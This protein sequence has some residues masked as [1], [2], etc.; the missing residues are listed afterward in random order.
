MSMTGKTILLTLFFFILSGGS[1]S[2]QEKL[3]TVTSDSTPRTN[4]CTLLQNYLATSTNS[5]EDKKLSQTEK[6]I[7]ASANADEEANVEFSYSTEPTYFVEPTPTPMETE[8][9]TEGVTPKGQAS[10]TPTPISNLQSPAD[11]VSADGPN[12]DSEVMFSLINSHRAELGKPPFQKD[13]ALCSLAKTRSFELHDELFV[14]GNLHSG[15][16]NRNLPYWITEDAKW[17]SNEA[18]TVNWWLHSPI[19]RRAIEGDYTYSCGAC[20]GSQCSQLFTSYAP[21]G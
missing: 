10:L 3:L 11:Y 21:K 2:A 15:L 17:G 18:G 6:V 14:N 9:I 19:H 5:C 4:N 16:Y 20:Q 13:D 12:L 7:K 1:A 8:T